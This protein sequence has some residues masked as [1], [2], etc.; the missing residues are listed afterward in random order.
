MDRFHKRAA[1]KDCTSVSKKRYHEENKNNPEYLAKRAK[2]AV[3][4]QVA[5]L[6]QSKVWRE[7][8]K[9]RCSEYR[10]NYVENNRGLINALCKNRRA[11]KS[12]QMPLW[13]TAEHKEQITEIYRSCPQGFHVDHIVPL[14]GETVSGLHV[15]WNLQHLSAAENLSKGNKLYSQSA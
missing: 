2:Y 9:D 15:P 3:D 1:S 12:Q 14:N 4:N 6:A 10:K 11:R 13:L 8:N 7:L 5:I